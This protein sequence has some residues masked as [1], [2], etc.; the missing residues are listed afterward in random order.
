MDKVAPI[1]QNPIDKARII[2]QLYTIRLYFQASE[3]IRMKKEKELK[4]GWILANN[5]FALKL[6]WR[7][8]PGKIMFT[9]LT[10]FVGVGL[11][12]ASLC[13]IRYATN[14][15][16]ANGEYINVLV[17]LL[18][19]IFAYLIDGIFGQI[20]GIYITPR[21]DE[22]INKR[23]KRKIFS[24]AS[25]CDLE[26][27]ENPGFY[28]KYTCAMV[29][30]TERCDAVFD[31]V[32]GFIRDLIE[33]FGAGWIIILAD[34]LMI[35]FVIIPFIFSILK[36]GGQKP[37]FKL[38]NEKMKVERRKAYPVRI[39]YQGAYAKELRTTDIAK[40]IIT[41][42]KKAISDS[43]EIYHKYGIKLVLYYAFVDI[44]DMF[45]GEYA[46]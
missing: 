31:S 37:G 12:L 23:L 16:D 18:V 35:V 13:I 43:I 7:A 44:V 19:L 38:H 40:P 21:F 26:C 1:G 17:L 22:Q 15:A 42:Y 5:L 41:R 34:P 33:F 6:L 30:G 32:V 27:Y 9:V 2:Q 29:E 39:F 28:E 46:I 11:E 8:C 36:A 4:Q 3:D 25:E 14:T 20:A 10:S 45:L 24:K